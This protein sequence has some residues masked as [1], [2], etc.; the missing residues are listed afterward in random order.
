M[1]WCSSVADFP[2]PDTRA[3]QVTDLQGPLG[4][5]RSLRPISQNLLYSNDLQVEVSVAICVAFA[6]ARDHLKLHFKPYF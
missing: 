5:V 4:F 6:A 3:L 2:T 1:Y